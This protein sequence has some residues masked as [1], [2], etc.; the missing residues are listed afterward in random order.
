MHLNYWHRNRCTGTDILREA[1][2]HCVR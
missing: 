1:G 2:L